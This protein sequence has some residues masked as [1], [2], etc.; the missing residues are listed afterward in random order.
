[1]KG[2]TLAWAIRPHDVGSQSRQPLHGVGGLL[3]WLQQMGLTTSAVIS[4]IVPSLPPPTT[5][6]ARHGGARVYRVGSHCHQDTSRIVLLRP[7]CIL[8]YQV[9]HN[10]GGRKRQKHNDLNVR[11][12]NMN[13]HDCS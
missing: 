11:N 10:A 5:D 1:M 7:R 3:E 8:R 13:D 2:S 12:T 9:E 6:R 4:S